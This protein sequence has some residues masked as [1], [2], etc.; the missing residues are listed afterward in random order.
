MKFLINRKPITGP[1]GGGNLF[2]KSFCKILTELGHEVVHTLEDN[3]NIFFIMNPRYDSLGISINE[4][5]AYKS[6]FPKTMIVQRINDCDARKG[7]KDVD[8]LLINCSR[9]LDATIFVSS[10]MK[11]YFLK[12]E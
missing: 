11:D 6:K 7:T 8:E 3:I 9:H 4:A 5:I 10:W 12:K 1:W 2:V